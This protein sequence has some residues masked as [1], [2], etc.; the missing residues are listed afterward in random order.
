MPLLREAAVTLR[1]ATDRP[2]RRAQEYGLGRCATLGAATDR[3]T[4][5]RVASEARRRGLS[6]SHLVAAL[7]ENVVESDL[8]EAVL[9][10]PEERQ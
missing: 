7:V 1:I 2:R 4:A 10:K 8:W 9:G 5:K 3:Y 6:K